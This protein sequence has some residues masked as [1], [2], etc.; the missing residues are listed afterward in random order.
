MF[1]SSNNTTSCHVWK[2]YSAIE[3]VRLQ[4]CEALVRLGLS[5]ILGNRTRP[6]I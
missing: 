6:I 4:T 2:Y 1:F 5:S 3:A